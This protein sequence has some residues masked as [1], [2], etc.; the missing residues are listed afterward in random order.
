MVDE[1]NKLIVPDYIF[2]FVGLLNYR[3]VSDEM[4]VLLGIGL[5]EMD[6]TEDEVAEL[7]DFVMDH[8]EWRGDLWLDKLMDVGIFKDEEEYEDFD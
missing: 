6:A 3:G 5:A 4:R 2:D 7:I 8:P 1:N